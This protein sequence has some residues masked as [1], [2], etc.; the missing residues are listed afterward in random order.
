MSSGSPPKLPALAQIQQSVESFRRLWHHEPIVD[1]RAASPAKLYE[2][3]D[4]FAALGWL[5]W[6]PLNRAFDAPFDAG[7]PDPAGGR[8]ASDRLDA[9]AFLL[10]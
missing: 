8:R 2:V 7:K 3:R 10:F 9:P 4:S 1:L 6:Q 5:E